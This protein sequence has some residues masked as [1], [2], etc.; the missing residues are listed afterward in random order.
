M[1]KLLYNLWRPFYIFWSNLYWANAVK[2]FILRDVD[3]IEKEEN[4]THYLLRMANKLFDNFQYTKDNL[5]QLGDSIPPPPEAYKRFAEGTL[6]DDCDGFHS[7]LYHIAH[8]NGI[9]CKLLSILS[10]KNDYG[11]C[12]LLFKD[13]EWKV[14]DYNNTM[15]IDVAKKHYKKVTEEFV[16]YT[17]TF[18]YKKEKLINEGKSKWLL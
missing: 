7:A 16:E 2:D 11:H 4:Y 8:C 15:T 5:E 14:L 18:D 12:V 13:N 17:A 3:H 1:L 9:E 10:V 6:K